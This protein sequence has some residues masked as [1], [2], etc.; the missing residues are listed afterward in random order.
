M[1]SVFSAAPSVEGWP[2]PPTPAAL[3]TPRGPLSERLLDDLRGPVREIAALPEAVD[4]PVDGDDSALAL[5]L[6]YEL[7]YRGL[8]DVDDAWEWEP[9]LLRERRRLEQAFEQRL[10]ELV[11]PPAVGLSRAEVVDA[12]RRLAA[13]SPGE[14]PSLSAHVEQAGTLSE[15]RELAVHR[16]AYQ[17]KEADPHSWAIPRIAGRAKAAL[18][19][20]QS[21]EYGAGDPAAVHA[22]LFGD[23]M[24]AL[25]LDRRYGAYL[26]QVPGVTLS[27]TNLISLFGLHRRWRGALIGHLA[28]FEMCSVGPMGRYAA[29]LRRL[30]LDDRAVRFYDE[31][32]V[33]DA[34]HQDIALHEMVGPLVEDE[35]FLGGEVV[36]GATALAALEGRFAAHVLGAWQGGRS[37][38]RAA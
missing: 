11:G 16:S 29:A 18:V 15:V 27:T 32:V 17:L 4:D 12:L 22:T 38:L 2:T 5:Y 30:G 37:S 8:P 33:A 6:C 28:L 3:P 36:F 24:D 23:T 7:H 9:S 21:D 19:E 34:L 26:D 31:H 35:P 1:T 10:V 20:I 25:G 14:G 13:P